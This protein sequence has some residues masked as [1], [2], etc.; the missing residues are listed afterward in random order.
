MVELAACYRREREGGDKG[1]REERRSRER[2]RERLSD[3]R[4]DCL[5][6]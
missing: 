3:G 1:K 2:E 6:N 5:G 4:A